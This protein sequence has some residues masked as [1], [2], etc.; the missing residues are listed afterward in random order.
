MRIVLC[1]DHQLLLDAFASALRDRGHDI[2]A[3]AH[4]A[5]GGVDAVREHRPDVC[6]MDLTFPTGS[7][8]EATAQISERFHEV[9]VLVLTASGD[10]RSIR[11]AW[12]AGAAGYVPKEQSITGVVQ[13][14]SQ[15][16]GGQMGTEPPLLAAVGARRYR[17]CAEIT[18]YLTPRESQVLLRISDGETTN[19][20]ARGLGVSYS[21]AR[22]H[23]QN[24]LSK[25]RVR[26]RLQAA[27][28]ISRDR[29]APQLREASQ[30]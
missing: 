8:L 3:T 20:I 7:G 21:T 30:R 15:L 13:A 28:L 9:K 11:A 24:A 6:I 10:A 17:A 23:V 4:T 16:A 25:L 27:A 18:R 2:V 29:L 19:E 1:D 14:L 5:A 26:S 22:T 12:D